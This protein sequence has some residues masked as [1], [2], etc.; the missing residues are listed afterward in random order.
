M[1]LPPGRFHRVRAAAPGARRCRERR[2]PAEAPGPRRSAAEESLEPAAR[3]ATSWRC[4]AD[5]RPGLAVVVAPDPNSREPRPAVLTLEKQIRR[6]ASTTWRVRSRRSARSGSPSSSTPSCPRTA[7]TWPPRCAT[8]A[9]DTRPAGTADRRPR[10]EDF[11][12]ILRSDGTAQQERGS[13]SCAAGSAPIPATAAATARA[14]PGGPSAGGSCAVRR[15]GSIRQI[16]GR[17]NTIAKTFDRVCE[18]LAGYGYLDRTDDGGLLHQR[19]TDSGCD[20]STA[21]RTC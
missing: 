12:R 13:P 9:R 20:A 3:R 19:A 18:V 21:R 2:L 16:Q 10:P 14:T 15:T 6:L 1:T 8:P 11:G 4:R 5:A 7:V 17:T